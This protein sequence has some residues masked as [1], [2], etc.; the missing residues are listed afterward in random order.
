MRPPRATEAT[1]LRDNTD[2][3]TD[4][5]IDGDDDDCW[6][7]VDCPT[8]SSRLASGN[9][10]V[11]RAVTFSSSYINAT[12]RIFSWRYSSQRRWFTATSVE[13]TA[14]VEASGDTHSCAFTI[15]RASATLRIDRSELAYGG[16]V[17]RSSVATTG[18]CGLA[19]T[20]WLPT[21]IQS[22]SVPWWAMASDDGDVLDWYLGDVYSSTTASNV[23]KRTF[24]SHSNYWRFATG[25]LSTS[26]LVTPL[27]PSETFVFTYE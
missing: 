4:G 20:Q 1:T 7:S 8:V 10:Q 27:D 15:G 26:W 12:G 18:A 11:R 23:N 9:L 25:T 3:D 19:D 16:A 24:A 17:T 14:W 6:G 21:Q 5:L 2:N 13:G 22:A